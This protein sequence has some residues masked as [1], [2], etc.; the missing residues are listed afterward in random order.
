MGFLITLKTISKFIIIGIIIVFI[1]EIL[2][3]ILAV[4]YWSHKYKVVSVCKKC[5]QRPLQIYY[6]ETNKYEYYCPECDVASRQFY[7]N[8]LAKR[9]W[10]K[11]QKN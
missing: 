1:L 7:S 2:L 3:T 11:L 5:K 4:I 10:A 8:I 9:E 6:D